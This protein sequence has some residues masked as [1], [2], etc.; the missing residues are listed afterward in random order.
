MD[1]DQ[2]PQSPASPSSPGGDSRRL[3]E[4]MHQKELTESRVNEDFVLALKKHG[5]TVT[6]AVLL[7]IAGF[8]G[9]MRWREYKEGAR[10]EAWIALNETELPRS[11]EDVADDHSNYV[12]VRLLARLR[13]A[14]AHLRTVQT[15]RPLDAGTDPTDPAVA[16]DPVELTEEERTDALAQAD[17]LYQAVLADDDNS[18][19]MTI[20]MTNAFFGRAAV[21]E[22]KGDLDAAKG[23]YEQ[24]AQRAG[25][26]APENASRARAR[27][28]D[29]DVVSTL[30]S[31]PSM[32]ELP[33]PDANSFAGMR[34]SGISLTS[35]IRLMPSLRDIIFPEDG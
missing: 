26:H 17:R 22:A 32:T 7:F 20:Y 1:Q 24:A 23:F 29:L 8:M 19:D 13:A 31:L 2:T 5:P 12:G 3:A 16:T 11:L 34:N 33:A 6:I 14:G 28:E 35:P 10:E 30:A 25:E 27:A 15:N 4:Q 21:A 9:L 18:A